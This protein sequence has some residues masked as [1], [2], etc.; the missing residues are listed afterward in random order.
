MNIID[1]GPVKQECVQHCL[2]RFAPDCCV[3]FYTFFHASMQHQA[4]LQ[5]SRSLLVVSTLSLG[6]VHEYVAVAT[7]ADCV[8]PLSLHIL[9]ACT[10]RAFLW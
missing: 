2:F 8:H 7:L 1:P 5:C 10:V 4:T 3:L 9:D 6:S